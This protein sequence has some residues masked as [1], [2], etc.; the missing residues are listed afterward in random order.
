MEIKNIQ[1][2]IGQI[3]KKYP[4][5]YVGVFG[6]TADG[7][8]KKTSDIDLLIGYHKGFSYFD[9]VNLQEILT[10]K[11]GKQVDLVTEGSLSPFMRESVFSKLKI[12]YG[13][14]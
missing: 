11:L 8:N 6:S 13:T 12:I 10:L 5:N 9:L 2:N 1:K 4:I 7:T 14:R 3:C